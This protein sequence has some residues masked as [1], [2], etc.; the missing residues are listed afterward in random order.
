MVVTA[1]SIEESEPVRDGL[2]QHAADGPEPGFGIHRL[3]RHGWIDGPKYRR[4]AV[5]DRQ[6]LFVDVLLSDIVESGEMLEL[7][8]LAG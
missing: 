2:L 5:S 4:G 1:F 3:P 6:H 8:K 7:G